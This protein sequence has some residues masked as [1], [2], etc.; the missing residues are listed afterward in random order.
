VSSTGRMATTTLLVSP[1]E[2]KLVREILA[3]HVPDREVRAFG[4][5]VGGAC[6]P[7]SDLDLVIMGDQPVSLEISAA[8]REAFSE[9][10]LPWKVD[11]L[12]WASAGDEFRQQVASGSVLI[13]QARKN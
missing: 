12:D 6:R 1:D 13:Q 2:G 7:Y 11:L 3:A 8:L 9:S 10:L 4:S 5:R